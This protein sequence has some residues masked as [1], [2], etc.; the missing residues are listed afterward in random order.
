MALQAT[1]LGERIE[2]LRTS[3]GISLDELADE[4]TIART[5][6]SRK[7]RK[8]GFTIDELVDISRVLDVQPASWLAT[9]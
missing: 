2:A 5:T 3:K 1:T 7:L 8:G 6:L 4:A 9:A